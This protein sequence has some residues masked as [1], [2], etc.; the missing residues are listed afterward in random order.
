MSYLSP[1]RL[2]FLGGCYANAATATNNDIASVF[3]VDLLKLNNQ[4]DLLLG[5]KAIPPLPDIFN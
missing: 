1:P 3:D 5:G 2:S 4:M